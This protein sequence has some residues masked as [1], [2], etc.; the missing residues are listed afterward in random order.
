MS[1][2]RINPAALESYLKEQIRHIHHELKDCDGL[3]SE[4]GVHKARVATR[5]VKAALE[6]LSPLVKKSAFK[7]LSSASR[8]LRRALG[9]I[10]ELDVMI[11]QLNRQKSRPSVAVEMAKTLVQLREEQLGK[12]SNPAVKKWLRKIAL[13]KRDQQE[14]VQLRPAT[15]PIIREAVMRDFEAFRETADA[16]ATSAESVDLHA[17]RVVAKEFRYQLEIAERAGFPQAA[18]TAKRFER[19]QDQLGSWHDEIVLAAHITRFALDA[20]LFEKRFAE[21]VLIHS[22]CKGRLDRAVASLA[23]FR[24]NWIAARDDLRAMIRE[25]VQLPISRSKAGRGRAKKR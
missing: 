21:A 20:S 13:N 2:P 17:L 15:A 5:R 4:Q 8:K 19:I 10:R 23:A 9:P 18:Q 14:L 24:K 22:L 11:K 16:A 6:L 3:L 7:E 12:L 25:L 1:T